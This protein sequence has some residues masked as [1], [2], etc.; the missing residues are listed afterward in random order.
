MSTS[1]VLYSIQ[2]PAAVL[3]LNRPD[4]RNALNRQLIGDIKSAFE[5]ARDDVAARCIIV[6]GAGPS[7]CAGMDLAELSETLDQPNESEVVAADAQRLSG[8]Y[9]FIYTLPKPTIAAINGPAVAGGAGLVTVC[10]LALADPAAKLGYPEARRGLVA[11]MVMPHLLRHVGERTARD[12]LL[13]GELIDA[14]EAKRVGLIND[15]SQPGQVMA[16]A[17]AWAKNVAESGPQALTNTKNLLHLFDPTPA[18][19]NLAWGS[20]NARLTV[21]CKEGLR[22]FFDK[23][24]APWMK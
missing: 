19:Q 16:M 24:P 5:R 18:G 10:D 7:F 17:M 21:E 11:A 23:R 14:M 22:A 12:L 8:L 15:V 9:E 4:K 13:R 20:A 1:L 3:T 2:A 6:I